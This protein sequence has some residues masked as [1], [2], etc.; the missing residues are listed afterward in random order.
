MTTVLDVLVKGGPVMVPILGCSVLTIATALERALFWTKLLRREDQVVAEVLDASRRD[1]SQAA[2]IAAQ[3]QD[4]PI[5]R[6][7]LAPLR[8]KQPSPET[9]RLAMETVG[10]RELVKMRK[11]DKL[12]ETVVAIAPLLGL[13]GTVTGLIATF[14][15][16]NIGGGGS[17]DQATAAASGIGEALITTAAGMV[18]A[19][20]A[21]LIFRV[22]VTL[23]AQQ[24]D[25]F[26]DAG[27][28]LELIYRQYWYEPTA[29]ANDPAH[30]GEFIG[31]GDR[32]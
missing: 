18:V 31:S 6:F 24:V 32:L 2:A 1:L 23:Q 16:L 22:L 27:N 19:I 14:S 26:S 5:G 20:L 25:Y 21:L 4:L 13:L 29:L 9:F 15:N 11:G 8:L 7:L 10:D 28:E 12:L 30:R 17:G 3:S